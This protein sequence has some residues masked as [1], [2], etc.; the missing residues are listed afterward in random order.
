MMALQPLA[1]QQV[2]V[3]HCM[4][5]SLSRGSGEQRP[6]RSRF[7]GVCVRQPTEEVPDLAVCLRPDD[8]GPVPLCM[9]FFF[10]EDIA[11]MVQFLGGAM[12]ITGSIG[13]GGVGAA[14]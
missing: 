8:K 9:S 5:W 13:T 6:G 12:M 14:V 10:S 3:S 1:L 4:P 11:R 2:P 7:L